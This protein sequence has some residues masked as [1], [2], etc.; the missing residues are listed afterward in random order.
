ME[1]KIIERLK[2][3]EQEV[4]SVVYQWYEYIYP[5]ILQDEDGQELCE[6]TQRLWESK[7]INY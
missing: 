5:D 7:T 2:L 6:I 4:L 3:N 1:E